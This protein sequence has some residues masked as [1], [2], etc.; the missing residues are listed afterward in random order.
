ML[1]HDTAGDPISGL[2]WSRRT[3][4]SIADALARY[5]MAISA[6]TVARLLHQMDFSLRVNRKQLA[7]NHSPNRNQQ[8]E[9]IADVRAR[10][11][12]AHWPIISVDTKKRELVG[13]FKNAG[14][15][16]DRQPR[17]VYDHDFRSDARGI[18]IP[19]G[20]YDPQAN[21]GA[22]IVGVS[23]DTPAFAA[24]AIAHWWHHEG[25]PTYRAARHLLILADTGG[26]NG[27][28][29]A[30][31][32]TELEA[33]L[34]TPFQLEVTVAH[35]PTGASKW[36]PIEHRLFSEISK[37]WAGEPLES[38][39]TILNFIRTTKTQTG[40]TISA[41]LDRRHYASGVHPAPEQLRRLRLRPHD[42]LPQWNY[43]ISPA[44]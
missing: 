20:L 42:T 30:A 43:T 8:F 24:H 18:A 7:T 3:T 39:Q 27:C 6:S 25:R 41:Y 33:Q 34:A 9:Y 5:G 14:A 38:Y 29:C 2:R 11:G 4:A 44:L 28:R 19:Y 15:R 35:Y 12:H 21:R 10:F 22:I 17:P 32:K 13:L 16:W 37:H 1:E 26:S 36:N 23:H 40:L 31:W